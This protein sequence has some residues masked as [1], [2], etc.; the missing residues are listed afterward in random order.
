MNEE[1]NLNNS[2]QDDPAAGLESESEQNPDK[3]RR[4]EIKHI[5][6]GSFSIDPQGRLCAGKG[7]WVTPFGMGDT[8]EQAIVFGV[9]RKR[10]F[11]KSTFNNSRQAIW[12]V[13]KSM[14][15]IGRNCVRCCRMLYK[16]HT[17]PSCGA[18]I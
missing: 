16:K 2:T 9:K 13:S 8:A 11:Y 17:F 12:N 4:N 7:G 5:L 3:A 15:N 1:Q 14:E 6:L 10:Y 18:C